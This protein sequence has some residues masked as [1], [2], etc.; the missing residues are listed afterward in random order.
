MTVMLLS[1]AGIPFTVGFIG[2]FYAVAAGVGSGLWG[3][4]LILV[5]NSV[6]GLFYYLRVLVAMAA[7]LSPSPNSLGLP[8]PRYG[9][10]GGWSLALV[11][12]LT[13]W[14]GLQPEPIIRVIRSVV[15]GAV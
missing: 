7:D 11:T 1:L 12:F 5:A 6:V 2:K 4:L 8:E 10:V 9:W 14:I 3:L 13:L 15:V